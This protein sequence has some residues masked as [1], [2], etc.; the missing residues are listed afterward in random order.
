MDV[1]W[2]T[3]CVAGEAKCFAREIAAG[4]KR[5]TA[6]PVARLAHNLD[7]NRQNVQRIINDLHEQGSPYSSPIC[8]TERNSSF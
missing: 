4:V 3:D 8:I 1:H 7:A 6:H 2:R 5:A